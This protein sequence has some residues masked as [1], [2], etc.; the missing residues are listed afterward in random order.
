MN[1]KQFVQ[2][3]GGTCNNWTWSWSFVND[4][5]RFV[6]FGVWDVHDEGDTALILSKDWE[7]SRR[8]RRQAGYT[9]SREHIQLIEKDGYILKTFPMEYTPSDEYDD[10]APSKIKGFTPVLTDKTLIQIDDCWYAINPNNAIEIPE[11]VLQAETL[12]EGAKF[13]LT[14]NAYERNPQARNKCLEHYGC[15]CQGCR[16]DFAETYGEIGYN[17]IHVHHLIPLS[18]IG[19]EYVVDPIN[20]L[21]PVCPNCHAMIHRAKPMLTMKQL[22]NCLTSNVMSK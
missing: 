5:E 16:F 4:V 9:Q 17:Y 8:G 2:S 6:I 1:R 19:H 15:F 13:Q 10:D 12:V 22:R 14:V 7:V 11:R 3:H 20:D 18:E 21:I